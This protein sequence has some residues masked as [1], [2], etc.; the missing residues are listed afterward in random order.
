MFIC[1]VKIFRTVFS[2]LIILA[3]SA[4]KVPGQNYSIRSFT[5]KDGLSHNN[6]RSIVRDSTGFLWIGTW[7]GI[8]RYDGYGF[9]NYYHIPGDTASIPY[10]SV[11]TLCIDGKDNLWVM[12]DSRELALYNRTDD[13]F[14]TFR[15]PGGFS[16]EDVNNI[17]TD[18]DGDLWIISSG[19]LYR[20]DWQDGEW[21]RLRITSAG[22]HVPSSLKGHSYGLTK[23]GVNKIW[24]CGSD[25][26][27]IEITGDQ[28]RILNSYPVKNSIF[29]KNP[30]FEFTKWFDFYESSQG[31]RWLF[32]NTGLHKFNYRRSQFE[33]YRQ[34]V[35]I[36]DFEG[37]RTYVWS[38]WENGKTF[39]LNPGKQL[40]R[41]LEPEGPEMKEA[42][43]C[44]N[45]NQAWLSA[46]SS[47]GQSLGMKQVICTPDYF[48][49]YLSAYEQ[50]KIPAIF[51]ILKDGDGNIYAGTMG[52]NY[53]LKY[54]TGDEVTSTGHITP[55]LFES[56][57]HVRQ[58]VGV[59]GG[60]WLGYLGNL[61]N[62]YDYKT[63]TLQQ[64]T[65]DDFSCRTLALNDDGNL[66]IGTNK[67]SLY[68]PI[69]GKTDL[70]WKVPENALIYDLL[71]EKNG[72][73]WAAM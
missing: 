62:F 45:E 56:A 48:H 65:P 51:S 73:V 12:T 3:L 54:T 68:H 47:K 44:H 60:I 41:R 58:M 38:W 49:N 18:R 52:N 25:I 17:S 4:G 57:G 64:H 37:N 23:T 1:S 24:V 53:I 7:D 8:S 13:N 27:E 33:E 19:A 50:G 69:S 46:I 20:R 14:I 32:S 72:I 21:T 63:G 5:T 43:Y 30:D 39:F 36:N 29:D 66:F 61:L 6:I 9:K 10:F 31:E 2:A 16:P 35:E 34:P 15:K 40:L 70:L 26:N 42:I 59:P 67:L 11:L 71:V 28:A 55:E 22:N